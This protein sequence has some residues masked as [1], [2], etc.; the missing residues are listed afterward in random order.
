MYI[1]FLD[2]IILFLDKN[3]KYSLCNPRSLLLF[4]DII[5]FELN[6]LNLFFVNR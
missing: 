3:I 1:K 2:K 4:S 6:E 5:N